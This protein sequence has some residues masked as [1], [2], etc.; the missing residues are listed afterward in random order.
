MKKWVGELEISSSR[1]GNSHTSGGSSSE[2]ER[3]RESSRELEKGRK[4]SREVERNRERSR[5][6]QEKLHSLSFAFTQSRA[7]CDYMIELTRRAHTSGTK[8]FGT[9]FKFC[10][11]HR[12]IE[13]SLWPS[14]IPEYSWAICRL[15]LRR[16]LSCVRMSERAIFVP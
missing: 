3:D 15:F 7:F 14:G 5:Y 9:I 8:I 13:P 4:W 2:I 10:F 6:E 16:V 1:I 12:N 11:G